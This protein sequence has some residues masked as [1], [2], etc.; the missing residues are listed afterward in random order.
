MKIG[1]LSLFEPMQNTKGRVVAAW[2]TKP[3]WSWGIWWNPDTGTAKWYIGQ[4][5]RFRFVFLSVP[6]VGHFQFQRQV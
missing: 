2:Q 6:R 5:I 4:A 3:W 1:P